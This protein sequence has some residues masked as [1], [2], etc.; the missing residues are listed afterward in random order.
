MKKL[1]ALLL[2]VLMVFAFVGCGKQPETVDTGQPEQTTGAR[3][4][5]YEGA[6]VDI[7]VNED[8]YYGLMG[9]VEIRY[10]DDGLGYIYIKDPVVLAF[11]VSSEHNGGVWV[12]DLDDGERVVADLTE[13]YDALTAAGNTDLAAKVKAAI[14]T[15]TTSGPYTQAST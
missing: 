11:C 6:C 8:G 5:S 14:D 7:G 2:A 12:L 9:D 3:V 13:V 4:E 10:E 15:I 1:L